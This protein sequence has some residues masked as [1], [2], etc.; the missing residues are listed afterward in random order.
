MTN[1][2]PPT[3]LTSTAVRAEVAG[4]LARNVIFPVS[5]MFVAELLDQLNA[6]LL[7]TAG[8]PDEA[9]RHALAVMWGQR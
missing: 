5:A 1:S 8:M 3:P 7:R 4:I 2:I 9:A 6:A